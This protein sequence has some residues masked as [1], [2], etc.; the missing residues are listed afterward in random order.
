MFRAACVRVLQLD[1]GSG[2]LV[3]ATQWVPR[4]DQ[5]VVPGN[6]LG[7]AASPVP[8]YLYALDSGDQGWQPLELPSQPFGE[9]AAALGAGGD[10]FL[11]G[12][13]SDCRIAAMK[14]SGCA[15]SGLGE[16]AVDRMDLLGPDDLVA[17]DHRYGAAYRS[18]DGG[19]HWS[20]VALPR[21]S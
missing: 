20:L 2:S 11:L 12:G 1:A 16:V 19:A 6:H 18:R 15:A 3:L 13:T 9:F 14:T 7:T 10:G 8:T 17:V 4:S 21:A 5:E